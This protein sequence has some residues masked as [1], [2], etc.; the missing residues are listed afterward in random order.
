MIDETTCKL[1]GPFAILIQSLMASVALASLL[2]KRNLESPRRPL[3]IWS[4]DTSKQAIAASLV[5]FTNVLVSS[6]SVLLGGGELSANPCGWYFLNLLLDTTIGVYILYLLL[7][8]TTTLLKKMGVLNLDSGIYG[9]PP[10]FYTWFK[11]LLVFLFSWVWVKLAV[12]FILVALPFFNSF[13]LWVLSVFRGSVDAQIIFTMF[14]FPLF[15]NI[16]QAI[17]TDRIIKGKS[18]APL[19][20]LSEQLESFI[21][22]EGDSI[23]DEDHPLVNGSPCD[24][25]N[26]SLAVAIPP[27]GA[28]ENESEEPG[29]PLF[30]SE[31]D[32]LLTRLAPLFSRGKRK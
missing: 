24:H 9:N 14:V 15:M 5:H 1:M 25:E 19:Q 4:M 3:L 17:L 2:Y 26:E 29:A 28:N 30:S 7:V 31:R 21:E 27:V 6:F 22:V 12:V 18:V 11:Q 16:V 23:S 32:D 20:N 13:A 10:S 8:S